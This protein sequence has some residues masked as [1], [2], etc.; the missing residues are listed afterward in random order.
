[1]L[2]SIQPVIHRLERDP[3]W[4][5]FRLMQTIQRLW[6]ET[7]G[8]AVAKQTSPLRI[9]RGTLQVATSTAAWAQNLAFQRQLIL[10]KLNP[11]I[12]TP[13]KDIR[14]L[15][16]EWHRSPASNPGSPPD[17]RRRTSGQVLRSTL[18]SP[19]Q[20]PEEALERWIKRARQA[21]QTMTPCPRCGHPCPPEELE[22]WSI[23]GFCQLGSPPVEI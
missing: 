12:S 9:Q 11:Q 1:M 7:V 16:A 21:Q 4:S 6:P 13:L 20:T 3:R 14:F 15:P 18:S 2:R 8:A 23:C 22:R 10:A 5:Q 17:P 19:P